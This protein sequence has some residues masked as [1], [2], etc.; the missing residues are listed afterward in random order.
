MHG[1]VNEVDI[2]TFVALPFCSALPTG[3][4]PRSYASPTGRS[5]GVEVYLF[6]SGL[7]MRMTGETN[8]ELFTVFALMSSIKTLRGNVLTFRFGFI[9]LCLCLPGKFPSKNPSSFPNGN[10]FIHFAIF[11]GKL[12]FFFL[13]CGH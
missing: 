5:K 11:S 2:F 12:A 4:E 6:Q 3:C 13:L 8:P 10:K 7:E 9:Y 1:W